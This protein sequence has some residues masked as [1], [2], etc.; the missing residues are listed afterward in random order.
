[1]FGGSYVGTTVVEAAIQS[2]P[3][4]KAAVAVAPVPD[5]LT[6]FSTPQGAVWTGVAAQLGLAF[7]G[8]AGAPRLIGDPDPSHL[9]GAIAK[10][11]ADP[12]GGSRLCPDVAKA[13]TDLSADA[14]GMDRDPVFWEARNMW[15]HLHNVTAP[16][17]YTDG[18]YDDQYFEG[19]HVF[20]L[21]TGSPFQYWTGPWPHQPP[22]DHPELGDFID[23]LI[24]WFDF[25]LKG[26]GDVP[27]HLGKAIWED[28]ASPGVAPENGKGEWHVSDAW[29]P[30]EATDRMFNLS[31][32]TLSESDA[33]TE[34]TYRSVPIAEGESGPMLG[35][36]GWL[37]PKAF[38]CDQ[39][40][41][42]TGATRL[43]Y[44]TAPAAEPWLLAG[45]P[46]LDLNITS[47][48]PGGIVNAFLLDQQTDGCLPPTEGG[49]GNQR[50][51]LVSFGAA[52]LL[53]VTDRF[54]MQPFPTGQPTHIQLELTD[55]AQVIQPGH[56]LV[57]V[58]SAGNPVDHTSRY[59]P[60]ITIH[61]GTADGPTRLSLPVVGA[62]A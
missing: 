31:G 16:I 43:V 45:I 22:D 26:M 6:L 36:G 29:P 34:R 15:P 11:T 49:S 8:F 59:A 17:I 46:R 5:L 24:T 38:L 10:I 57:L 52:D 13:F 60:T 20:P 27:P 2:P 47:D 12:T 61:A 4:L 19:P 56:R 41:P 21:F 33:G 35:P 3:H 23:Y 48:Q 39:T 55:I 25:W 53:H 44:S 40:D 58:I 18:Y 1:M 62:T 9:E 50:A 30:P 37:W 28:A 51:A 54:G 14:V 32:A 42:L 7:S